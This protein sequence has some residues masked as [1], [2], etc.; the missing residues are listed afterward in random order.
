MELDPFQKSL[1]FVHVDSVGSLLRIFL[2]QR[3][4]TAFI[5]Q[6]MF[7]V[8]DP[9]CIV[10]AKNK[11]TDTSALFCEMSGVLLQPFIKITHI[12]FVPDTILVKVLYFV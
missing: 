2:I 9:R 3:P 11:C 10:S 4:L 6:R 7:I 8:F 12:R 5:D 1:K